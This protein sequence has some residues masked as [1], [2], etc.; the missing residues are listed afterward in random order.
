MEKA[1]EV[2]RFHRAAVVKGGI[3]DGIICWGL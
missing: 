1:T 2:V 3:S